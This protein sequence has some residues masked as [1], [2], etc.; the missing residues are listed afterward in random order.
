[1]KEFIKKLFRRSDNKTITFPNDIY[2]FVNVLD[3]ALRDKKTNEQFSGLITK[4]DFENREVHV[5][6]KT[7]A[8]VVPF[9]DIVTISRMKDNRLRMWIKVGGKK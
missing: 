3:S 1:M 8:H 6:G 5:V 7:E 9:D 4:V 2:N